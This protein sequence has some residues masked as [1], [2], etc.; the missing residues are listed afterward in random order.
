M[1]PVWLWHTISGPPVS[2]GEGQAGGT[3]TQEFGVIAG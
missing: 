1:P 3:Y 2:L